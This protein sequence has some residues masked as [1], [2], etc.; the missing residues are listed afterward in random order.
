LSTE[1]WPDGPIYS[2][3]KPFSVK[4]GTVFESNHV[5]LHKRPWSIAAAASA[6][7]TSRT[8]TKSTVGQIVAGNVALGARFHTDEKARSWPQRE[9]PA[10]GSAREAAVRALQRSRSTRGN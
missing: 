1:T 7:S 2:C 8:P 5:P 9:R 10:E 6:R 3:R 4:V